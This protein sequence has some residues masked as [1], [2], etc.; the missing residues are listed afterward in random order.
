MCGPLHADLLEKMASIWSHS[1]WIGEHLWDRLSHGDLWYLVEALLCV[2]YPS[3]TEFSAILFLL[4]ARSSSNSPRS[5]QRFRW[6]LVQHFIQIRQ[7][8]KNFPIDPHCKYRPLSG[9]MG[10]YFTRCRIWMKCCTRVCL[11][12]SND[13]GEFELDR[14]RS[15]KNI[16]ENSFA[17]GHVTRN[18]WYHVHCLDALSIF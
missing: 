1:L 11:Q 6:T 18:R 13:R 5:F 3:A 2:S 16:A 17:L 10:N 12:P 4:L 8:A 7:R 9:S 14:A 15:K